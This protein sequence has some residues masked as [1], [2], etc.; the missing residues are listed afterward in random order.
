MLPLE[1][2]QRMMTASILG[3][4]SSRLGSELEVR[5]ANAVDRFGIYRNNS[6]LSLTEALAVNFPVTVRLVDDRFFRWVSQGFIRQHPPREARLCAYG[7]ELPA[8]LARLPA[9]RTVPY[10]AEVA[11]L[12][13]AIALSLQ[14]EEVVSC[15]IAALSRLGNDAGAA[16]LR[17]Q[18][19]LQLIPARWPV[20]EIWSA[21]QKEP[22]ELP[23]GIARR[24]SHVEVTRH[25]H[26]ICLTA[27]PLGR[28]AFRRGLAKGL[29]LDAAVDR[30]MSRDPRFEPAIELA[31]LFGEN[32]VTDVIPS[33]REA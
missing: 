32:I 11:R 23:C 7:A 3:P 15:S 30:A 22:I 5:G 8:Y 10:V 27:L 31:A 33:E 18:R 29:P 9:C 16:R 28:F 25:A 4:T 21:H 17:L 1:S 12:E 14:A 2:L 26:R 6:L 19:S 24:A 20:V 13:W